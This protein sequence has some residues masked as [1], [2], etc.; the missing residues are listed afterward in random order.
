[1]PAPTPLASEPLVLPA[2]ETIQW[3]RTIATFPPGQGFTPRYYFAGIDVFQ[4]A[5]VASGNGWLFTVLSTDLATK[6]AGTY[7]WTLYAE[8][9]S[10]PINRYRIDNGVLDVTPNLVT[11]T[12]G[13]LQTHAERTLAILVAAV[14]GRLTADI[15]HY[16]I[17]NRQVAK[18]P[19]KELKALRVEYAW[20]VW[21][22]K[23][24]GQIGAKVATEFFPPDGTIGSPEPVTLPL[25]LQIL[26]YG[27]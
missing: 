8:D 6:P 2:G 26:R 14:E 4:L 10:T 27:G 12:P 1:M 18:I 16:V 3:M 23:N 15:E 21:R 25:Y 9:T 13:Q 20:A 17:E 5:G 19:M 7:R 22:E 11:A 24:P